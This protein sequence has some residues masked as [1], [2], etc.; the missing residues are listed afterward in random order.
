MQHITA[1]KEID[2]QAKEWTHFIQAEEGHPLN[3]QQ[4]LLTLEAMMEK[5]HDSCKKFDEMKKK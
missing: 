5:Y 4:G 3:F 1:R 2:R